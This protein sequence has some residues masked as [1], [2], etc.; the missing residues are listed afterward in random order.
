M[1]D[2]PKKKSEAAGK[3]KGS[4]SGDSNSSNTSNG[5]QSIDAEAH[6]EASLLDSN[7]TPVRTSHENARYNSNAR[8]TQELVVATRVKRYRN[9]HGLDVIV[10][11]IVVGDKPTTWYKDRQTL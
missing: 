1:S 5:Q 8:Y 11:D 3:K 4:S 9:I 6:N 7:H 2:D 10:D